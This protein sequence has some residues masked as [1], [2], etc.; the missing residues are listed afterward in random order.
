MVRFG[1]RR[2]MGVVWKKLMEGTQVIRME[3]K[4]RVFSC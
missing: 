3:G 2:E 1:L 4:I